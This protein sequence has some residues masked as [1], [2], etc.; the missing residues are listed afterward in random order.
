MHQACR[1]VRP[2]MPEIFYLNKETPKDAVKDGIII[3]PGSA[4]DTP[5]IKRWSPYALGVCSGWMQVRGAQRRRNADAGFALSDHAD[6]NGLLSAIEA[7]GAECVYATHGFSSQLARY[8]REEKGLKA[9]IVKTSFGE[10]EE[11]N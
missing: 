7:T 10:D 11:E 4:V 5:W 3:C 1:L 6:W 2:E 9:D 8:L